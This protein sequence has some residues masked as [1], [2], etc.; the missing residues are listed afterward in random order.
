MTLNSLALALAHAG[1]ERAAIDHFDASDRH[2]PRDR[3]HAPRRAGAREP[4][5]LHGRSG[6]QERAVY[7]LEAALDGLEPDSR[8]YRHVE[9]QLTQA[10]PRAPGAPRSATVRRT[11]GI[12]SEIR[13]GEGEPP[14]CA[15]YSNGARWVTAPVSS[16]DAA[17][18]RHRT[19]SARS[20]SGAAAP[21]CQGRRLIEA[22]L[23]D[24]RSR[25]LD[26]GTGNDGWFG[27]HCVRRAGPR[28][29]LMRSTPQPVEA[30]GGRHSDARGC[31]LTV[32]R[33]TTP[34]SFSTPMGT[35][36]K[37]S[38]RRSFSVLAALA[39]AAS[40]D[41]ALRPRV[42]DTHLRGMREVGRLRE[43]EDELLPRRIPAFGSSN[44]TATSPPSTTRALVRL[45][46]DD[47]M[48]GR[49]PGAGRRDAR[50]DLRLAVTCSYI[51]PGKVDLTPC[52]VLLSGRR[53]AR[54][55]ERGS[56]GPEELV[57]TAVVGSGGAVVDGE[58]R[59]SRARPGAGAVPLLAVL[60]DRRRRVDHPPCRRGRVRRDARS[61]RR[62]RASCHRKGRL[63]SSGADRYRHA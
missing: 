1:D 45:H 49:V 27:A 20:T 23:R 46:D 8:A 14:P 4:R 6:R 28:G 34:H 13:P 54:A 44:E 7:C 61:C 18:T 52:I 10:S 3:R 56:A 47:L 40:D 38:F 37:L 60:L 39:L 50:Q 48:F 22:R 62:S 41:S 53:R 43:L 5:F 25:L 35:T 33:G 30:G 17:S 15:G 19:K 29:R 2:P 42:W 24:R 55:A 63:R 21:R 9:E 31:G 59:G 51:A 36:W 32:T 57:A 12:C 16:C 26:H 58:R 11:L